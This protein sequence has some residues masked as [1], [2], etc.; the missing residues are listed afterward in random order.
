MRRMK[1]NLISYVEQYRDY[2]FSEMPFGE[3]D[4]LVLSEVAYCR[5][6]GY[7]ID[8]TIGEF[9]KDHLEIMLRQEVTKRDDRKLLR[10]IS[11]AGRFGN[12][13]AHANLERFDEETSEQFSAVTFDLRNGE[14]CIAFRGTDSSVAGWK[15]DF[16]MSF[17]NDIEA[18]KAAIRYAVSAMSGLLNPFH[19]CGHSKGGNLAVYAAMNLPAELKQRLI[20][21]YNFDGPGFLKEIYESQNYKEIRPLI[22]KY[23][24]QTSI[25]GMMLESD[26]QYCVIRSEAKGLMQHVVYSWKV[27]GAELERVEELDGFARHVNQVIEEWLAELPF[28]ERKRIVDV[29]FD[30]IYGTGISSFYDLK[31]KP[32][33]KIKAA[34]QN[35]ANV[36][37]EEKQL[38]QLAIKRLFQNSADGLKEGL[39]NGRYKR[40]GITGAKNQ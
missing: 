7:Y 1:E 30:V 26:N 40:T 24:P 3:L 8:Q 23:I 36:E 10:A 17:Q 25:I 5:F 2:D 6:A 4:A 31:Y 20:G 12:L 29:V 35:V 34:M 21:I 32:H 14:Y 18:Q 33:Q 38:I 13:I 28:E 16:S 27:N 37:E 19:F 22:H 9:A 39:K 15:E 11:K